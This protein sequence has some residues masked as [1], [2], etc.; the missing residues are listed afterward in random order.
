[1]GAQ[2]ST[3]VAWDEL[4]KLT[5]DEFTVM[6]TEQRLAETGDPWSGMYQNPQDISALVTE[7]E[8]SLEILGDAPWPPQY[9]KQPHEPPRVSPSR[10]KTDP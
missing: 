2:V 9:P 7:F 1:M 3:P 10:A 5:P 6:S 4:E 8:A